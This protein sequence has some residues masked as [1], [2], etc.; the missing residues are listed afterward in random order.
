M[1]S[2]YVVIYLFINCSHLSSFCDLHIFSVCIILMSEQASTL[3]LACGSSVSNYHCGVEEV[4]AF[5]LYFVSTVHRILMV[6]VW[7]IFYPPCGGGMVWWHK[8]YVI[9]VQYMTYMYS[10]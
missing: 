7:C 3:W 4:F 6:T 10:I 9:D 1:S 5:V 8:I 2:T